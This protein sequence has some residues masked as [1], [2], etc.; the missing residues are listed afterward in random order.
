MNSWAALLTII[1]LLF[2]SALVAGII[3]IRQKPRR[4]S[5][6]ATKYNQTLIEGPQIV[7]KL[8]GVLLIAAAILPFLRLGNFGITV[9][10][11]IVFL[12]TTLWVQYILIFWLRR[13]VF[14]ID[15]LKPVPQLIKLSTPFLLLA[16]VVS[17]V[18]YLSFILS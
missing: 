4:V 13:L 14:K 10:I 15:Q 7:S 11:S 5:E 12:L 17:A 16:L 1:A 9:S 8:I 3:L 2:G 18:A 6:S